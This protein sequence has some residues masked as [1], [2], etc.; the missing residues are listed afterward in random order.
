M[1]YEKVVRRYMGP[2]RDNKTKYFELLLMQRSIRSQKMPGDDH[3]PS[4]YFKKLDEQGLKAI[5]SGMDECYLHHE[6]PNSC[7]TALLC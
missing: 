1:N 7:K 5:G 2:S 3:A 6:F 4:L